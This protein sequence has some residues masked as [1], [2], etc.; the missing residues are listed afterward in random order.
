MPFAEFDPGNAGLALPQFQLQSQDAAQSLMQRAQQMS[1]QRQQ[2]EMQKQELA[3]NLALNDNRLQQGLLTV[4]QMQNQVKQQN[5]NYDVATHQAAAENAQYDNAAAL[6]N[7]IADARTQNTAL[8]SQ[9]PDDLKQLQA[10]S[11]DDPGGNHSA[12]LQAWAKIQGKY[13]HLEGDPFFAQQYQALM[14][15]ALS[16]MST[17]QASFQ[18]LMADS[19]ADLTAQVTTAKTPADLAAVEQDPMFKYVLQNPEFSKRYDARQ[20]QLT[21]Q[22][23]K[24]LEAQI[25]AGKQSR[26]LG[27]SVADKFESNQTVV[28]ARAAQQA[29]D[30][31]VKQLT[32]AKPTTYSDQ[33]A[34]A[35]FFKIIDP[36]MG[37][38][39]SQ[40][41]IFS[42]LQPG[43]ARAVLAAR[44]TVQNG[45]LLSDDAR[46]ALRGAIENS[47]DSQASEYNKTRDSFGSA[48]DAAGIDRGY[49]PAQMERPSQIKQRPT[50]NTGAQAQALVDELRKRGLIQ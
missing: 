49:L 1:V 31:A 5:L 39:A 20:Q 4:Q 9:L 41:E 12:Y 25:A 27:T 38:N 10:L 36:T 37:F 18:A 32:T 30:D 17:H 21:D 14:A 3:S 34:L 44:N 43:V 16:E 19:S 8:L 26:D 11:S 45:G 50:V 2:L 22:Q 40:E 7:S 42:K 35:S 29:Y 23:N 33:A 47:F 15:P 6:Q 13:S 28:R 24:V 48:L 46:L